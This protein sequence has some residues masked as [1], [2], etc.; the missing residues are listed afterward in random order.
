MAYEIGECGG[1]LIREDHKPTLRLFPSG[2]TR[3]TAQGKPDYAGYLSP[4]VVQRFGQYMLQHQTQSDGTQRASDNWKRGI[5][6]KEYFSSLLRHFLDV[7]LLHEEYPA[8]TKNLEDALCALF[9]NVQ[10][11]LH[12][13]LLNREEKDAPR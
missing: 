9:F 1:T 4:L 12:E 8:A 7:W 3:D 13:T 10:G 11:Y 2:A 6:R 5:P